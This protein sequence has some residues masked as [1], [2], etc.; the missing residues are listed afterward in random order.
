MMKTFYALTFGVMLA[1]RPVCAQNLYVSDFGS[2]QIQEYTTGG[3]FVKTFASGVSQ[4]DGLTSANGFLFVASNSS[5]GGQ[6]L[7]YSLS[8]PSAAPFSFGTGLSDSITGL[9]ADGAGNVY[10]SDFN[11]NAVKEYNASGALLSSTALNTP[12]GL[13]FGPNGA[14]YAASN[15]DNEVY[16]SS[17]LSSASPLTFTAFAAANAPAGLAFV[18]STLYAAAGQGASGQGAVNLYDASG[19]QTGAFE[20]GTGTLDPSSPYGLAAGAGGVFVSDQYGTAVSQYDASGGYV[21][22][23][24]AG[25]SQ[26][27]GLVLA[28]ASAPEPSAPVALLL[29]GAGLFSLAV[30]RRALSLKD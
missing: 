2:D 3:A 26:P 27:L 25:L 21:R 18:G 6:I 19:T 20:D 1:C 29:G 12:V 30:R 13:A 4:P 5:A 9:A 23:L 16:Q 17:S 24:S 10:V 28:P 14:L 11:A 8:D 22:T 15:S 7:R